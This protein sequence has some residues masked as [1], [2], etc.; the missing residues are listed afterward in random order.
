[1]LLLNFEHYYPHHSHYQIGFTV[2][3]LIINW[4]KTKSNPFNVLFLYFS[5][6]FIMKLMFCSVNSKSCQFVLL[7]MPTINVLI[8]FFHFPPVVGAIILYNTFCYRIPYFSDKLNELLRNKP[9]GLKVAK[10]VLMSMG[11]MVDSLND[12]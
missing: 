9:K 3:D 8:I 12:R 1:M 5:C 2:P 4:W 11:S 10:E 7:S 6:W